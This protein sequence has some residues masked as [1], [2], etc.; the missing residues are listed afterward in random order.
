MKFGERCM[1]LVRIE[2]SYAGARELHT[3]MEDE[4][5]LPFFP[6]SDLPEEDEPW[7]DGGC[8][9]RLVAFLCCGTWSGVPGW[10]RGEPYA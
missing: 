2:K 7:F 4:T 8:C 1:N 10:Q 6:A 9:R 5:F 3:P